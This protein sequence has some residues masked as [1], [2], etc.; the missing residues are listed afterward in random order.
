MILFQLFATTKDQML[1]HVAIHTAK[2]DALRNCAAD[3]TL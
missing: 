2:P 1:I 3:A